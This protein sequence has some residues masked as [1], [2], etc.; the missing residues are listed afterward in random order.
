[1]VRQI[2][3]GGGDVR[4]ATPDS[5]LILPY[6]PNVTRQHSTLPSWKTCSQ[7]SAPWEDKVI[8]PCPNTKFA[9]VTHALTVWRAF[10][11]FVF[12]PLAREVLPSIATILFLIGMF[13]TFT[14]LM[15]RM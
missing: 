11:P 5:P 13:K 8:S 9:S 14:Q 2:L 10:L 15:K 3:V 7:S 4:R 1:M 12:D 6:D